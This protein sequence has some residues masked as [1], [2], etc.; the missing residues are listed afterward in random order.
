LL[1]PASNLLNLF[2]VMPYARA[3]C[4]F[5]RSRRQQSRTF[6]CKVSYAWCRP[7]LDGTR[8]PHPDIQ[9]VGATKCR[10]GKESFAVKLTPVGR[11][12]CRGNWQPWAPE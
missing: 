4:S 9:V 3:K 10:M 8:Y 6:H 1:L 7:P 11:R 12:R 2:K 5:G